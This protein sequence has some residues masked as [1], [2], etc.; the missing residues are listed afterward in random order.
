MTFRR[1]P[2]SSLS[3]VQANLP[4][5]VRLSATEGDQGEDRAVQEGVVHPQDISP[6]Q[7]R[8]LRIAL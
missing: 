3:K 8:G 4:V 1:K 2:F 6:V 5:E 7:R